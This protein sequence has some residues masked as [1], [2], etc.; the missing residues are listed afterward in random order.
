MVSINDFNLGKII[1]L[2]NQGLTF[3]ELEDLTSI[4]RST[5]HRCLNK[6]N[7]S[8]SI[9]RKKGS[10][11]NNVL[12]ND[13]INCI[14]LIHN[15]N[16]TISAPKLNILFKEKQNKEVSVE[17]V[18]RCLN[19]L[20]LYAYSPY[21]KPLLSTKNILKRKELCHKWLFMPDTY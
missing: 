4:P 9:V 15:E 3:R 16:P 12:N 5:I 20:G 13:D 19:T 8:G 14:K 2:R 11:R 18:R 6:Y 10:G 17:T 7:K 1:I 21:R